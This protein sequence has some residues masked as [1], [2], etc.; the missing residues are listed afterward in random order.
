M[1]K[2]IF[3]ARSEVENRT[4]IAMPYP[5]EHREHTRDRIVRSAHGTSGATGATEP[6]DAH[7]T[8]RPTGVTPPSGGASSQGAIT[9]TW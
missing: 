2:N 7:G 3:P 6:F 8:E 5:R 9:R 4:E 1:F